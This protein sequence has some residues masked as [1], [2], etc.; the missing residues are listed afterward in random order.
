MYFDRER[1][2]FELDL[3]D[4]NSLNELVEKSK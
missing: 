4:A 3:I 1:E 2:V